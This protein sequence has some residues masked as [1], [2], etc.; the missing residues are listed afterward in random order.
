MRK[1]TLLTLLLFLILLSGCAHYTADDG[2]K[3]VSLEPTSVTKTKLS[4][5]NGEK[6][7]T[8]LEMKDALTTLTAENK[9]LSVQA[10]DATEAK[11]TVAR[12]SDENATLKEQNVTLR[13][14]A[15]NVEEYKK[16]IGDLQANLESTRS[17]LLGYT[18]KEAAEKAKEESEKRELITL[19]AL[20][21]LVYPKTFRSGK[22]IVSKAM[23]KIDVVLLPLGSTP[24]SEKQIADIAGSV[25]DL[26][27]QIIIATGSESNTYQ[28]VR[29]LGKSAVLA[30]D[31]AI[32]TDYAFSSP[33]SSSGVDLS[34]DGSRTLRISLVDMPQSD[35]F[36]TFLANGD[37]KTL[38]EKDKKARLGEVNAVLDGDSASGSAIFGASLY[39]PSTK[40]WGSFS[41]VSYRQT[42]V[43]WPL[44]DAI[45]S[46]GY[47]DT[48]RQTHFSD[49][50]D[51]GNT[52]VIHT[53]KE[54]TDYLF[55][56][57]ALPL[58]STVINLGEESI[59]SEGYSRQGLIASYLIP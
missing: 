20:E 34:L 23:E 6:V 52:I 53:L 18:N 37:W 31:G 58:S 13:E 1:T 59:E 38:I 50:T 48:Y 40:D 5:I 46:K 30:E 27:A 3:K 15:Q 21:E 24:Y 16:T 49:A 36:E 32:I 7:M 47:L 12:L 10:K 35:V 11:Q 29:Q 9:K 44:A 42:D 17:S 25:S 56:K 39:E 14:Q 2:L 45:I 54:R 28:M 41:P 55:A 19:P 57:H 4:S 22:T 26:N 43:V 33:A 51:A 8:E